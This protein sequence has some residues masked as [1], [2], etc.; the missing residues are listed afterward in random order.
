MSVMAD[1]SRSSFIPKENTGG[2]PA[3]VRRRRTFNVFG[4]IATTVL[5]GSILLVG[6][7]YF[8]KQ[9]ANAKLER[10]KTELN[11][12]KGLFK[13]DSIAEVREFDRRLQ[14][15]RQLL[16][17]HVAPHKIFAALEQGTKQKVQFTSLTYKYDPSFDILLTIQGGTQ[18]FKTLAL[19]ALQF[20]EDP[21]LK[22]ILFTEVGTTEVAPSDTKTDTTSNT[23]KVSFTLT[24]LLTPAAL[25]YD[26]SEA[27][28]PAAF[29]EQPETIVPAN[30]QEGIT[31]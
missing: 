27:G 14:G 28:N 11:S 24:G 22:N 15:A 23:N 5:I 26:G 7:T 31:Q 4:F 21:M 9:T 17:N 25:D 29:L 16:N 12:Q 10:V 3:R 6:G 30:D 18:E 2:V 19:Q 20:G 8:L 13:N 1:I